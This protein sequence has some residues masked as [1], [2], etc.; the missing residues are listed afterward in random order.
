MQIKNYV[1]KCG[2]KDFIFKGNGNQIGI[3]CSKCGKW[4]KWAD[5]NEKN[6]W[7]DKVEVSPEAPAK[8]PEVIAYSSVP[9]IPISEV[10]DLIYEALVKCH[11]DTVYAAQVAKA[12]V[13]K[14]RV[15]NEEEPFKAFDS[16]YKG[17]NH[18]YMGV[19]FSED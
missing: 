6:L 10:G 3:Y 8:A 16:E 17:F 11:I 5:K 18:E 12:T 4:L 13:D 1:C 9:Q 7:S 19:P 14:I 15:E 2:H